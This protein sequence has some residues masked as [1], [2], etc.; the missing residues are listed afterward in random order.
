MKK[1]AV[2]T[3]GLA[4]LGI[5]LISLSGCGLRAGRIVEAAAGGALIGGIIG[6]QSGEA[7]AGALIG[8]AITGGLDAAHQSDE[9]GM[10]KER[11][12]W[13]QEITVNIKQEDGSYKPI[14]LRKSEQ[15]I[16]TDPDGNQYIKQ[17]DGSLVPVTTKK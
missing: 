13:E 10:K 7:L 4:V 11:R 3:A 14:T 12:E 6:Y 5:C 9:I 17:K 1:E 16:Y 8:A 2:K 15:N